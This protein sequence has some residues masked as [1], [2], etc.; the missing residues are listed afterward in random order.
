MA[1]KNEA[2][3][4]CAGEVHSASPKFVRAAYTTRAMWSV[5]GHGWN[6]VSDRNGLE[7]QNTRR[8]QLE[9]ER[10]EYQRSSHPADLSSPICGGSYLAVDSF[11]GVHWPA[12]GLR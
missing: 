1:K 3:E 12:P 4:E 7:P 8:D 5:L 9:N 10:M 6:E 11:R 2:F